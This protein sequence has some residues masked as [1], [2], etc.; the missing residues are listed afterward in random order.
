MH[1][2]STTLCST[3]AC[4]GVTSTARVSEIVVR[5]ANNQPIASTDDRDRDADRHARVSEPESNSPIAAAED[6]DEQELD[7]QHRAA[8]CAGSWRSGRRA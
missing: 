8:T 6:A 7:G 4:S 3:V 5:T 1:R 2:P